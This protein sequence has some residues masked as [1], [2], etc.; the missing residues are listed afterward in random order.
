M[1]C[2][3]RLE[4]G[5]ESVKCPTT[6]ETALMPQRKVPLVIVLH[7]GDV[8]RF[9]FRKAE[10]VEGKLAN[11]DSQPMIVAGRIELKWRGEVGYSS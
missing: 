5:M 9:C 2:A 8:K 6:H 11:A 3:L 4:E 10:G 1:A 7:L